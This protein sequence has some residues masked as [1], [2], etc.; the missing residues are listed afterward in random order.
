[1]ITIWVLRKLPFR[2]LFMNLIITW[3]IMSWPWN[4]IVRCTLSLISHGIFRPFTK[5]RR[6]LIL[7][8]SKVILVSHWTIM[9]SILPQVY[10]P[11]RCSLIYWIG[12]RIVSC[13][14][15]IIKSRASLSF[16]SNCI[17]RALS[18]MWIQLVLTWAENIRVNWWAIMITLFIEWE[19]PMRVS[20]MSDR[21]IWLVVSWPRVPVGRIEFLRGWNSIVGAFTNCCFHRVFSW[22][23]SIRACNWSFMI[24]IFIIRE[25][26]L[27]ILF[28]NHPILWLVIS[29]AGVPV[30]R[31]EFL[32][33]WNSIVRAF[34]NSRFHSVFSWTKSV[35]ADARSIMV[36]L[37]IV[38]ELPLRILFMNKSVIGL[39]M[40]WAWVL[41]V[42]AD[43]SWGRDSVVGAFS[44]FCFQVVRSW[45]D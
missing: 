8:W 40:A 36:A 44:Y 42:W 9:I 6:Q 15:G 5:I 14:T 31:T 25:F 1:M 16:H 20:F 21:I 17:M 32:W 13:R 39:I 2:S 7:P 41:V 4:F 22:T 27:R 28:M 45:T 3:L 43:I 23:K 18:N 10:F 34:T 19:L 33:S 26:P 24:S 12:I 37:K 11:M 30:G 35:R 29:R 38:R